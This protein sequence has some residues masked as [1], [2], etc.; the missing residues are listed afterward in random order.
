MGWHNSNIWIKCQISSEQLIVCSVN[1]TSDGL[2]WM[3]SHGRCMNLT[4]DQDANAVTLP[5]KYLCHCIIALEQTTTDQGYAPWVAS[6]NFIP[7]PIVLL[8][9]C[10][11]LFCIF[12]L[13]LIS[14]S[15]E[16]GI[17]A[18]WI[19]TPQ[20]KVMNTLEN[21]FLL[22]WIKKIMVGWGPE[23]ANGPLWRVDTSS[24]MT[25]TWENAWKTK[26]CEKIPPLIEA[27]PEQQWK[28]S[29]GVDAKLHWSHLF[30]FSVWQEEVCT[31]KS[32]MKGF[33]KNKSS[34]LTVGMSWHFELKG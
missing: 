26:L 20:D 1:K 25:I 21:H 31:C 12:S 8:C 19:D 27:D 28:A 30:V 24:M 23:F 16:T 14:I 33:V 17:L 11:L 4:I 15:S 9:Q 13:C 5:C 6:Q 7:R 18:R 29:L 34:P 2:I 32:A 10:F 3:E 22:G